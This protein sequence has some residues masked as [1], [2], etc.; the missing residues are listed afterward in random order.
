MS[1]L[2]NSEV[3][4][5]IKEDVESL[6]G[7]IVLLKGQYCG[8]KN[9]CSG[10]FYLNFKDEP[11]IKV[12]K[13][14]LLEEEWFGILIHEYCH[15]LQWRDDLKAWNNFC[16]YDATYSQIILKPEKYKKELIALINLEINCEKCAAKIIKNNKLF[17]H[18][19]YIQSAN[20]IIYK[21]AFLYKYGKWPD[22]NR[23]YKKIQ[24]YAPTKILKSY[25]EYLDI[26]KEI[27]MYYK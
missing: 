18:Q 11:I 4:S 7:K 3:F 27:Y 23:S 5:I 8:G 17:D 21:Y 10:L 12:A 1:S 2:V 20:A 13:G 19:K 22:D 16:D 14:N 24:K 15:F 25:R 9:K 26:P 6:D